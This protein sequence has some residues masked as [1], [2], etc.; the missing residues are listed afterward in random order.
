MLLVAGRAGTIFHHVRF[1][2]AVLLV[3]SFA[4]PIDC[5]DGDA[6]AKTI[7]QDGRKFPGGDIAVVTLG[8]VVGELR[9]TRRDFA[10]IEKSFAPVLLKK[11]DGK[12]SAEDR[13]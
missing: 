13:H 8:A 12:E 1:V 11:Q 5:F 9:V 2:E 10:S 4:F 3:T 7:A 6:V